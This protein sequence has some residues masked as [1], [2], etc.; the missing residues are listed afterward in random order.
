MSNA[1]VV[2]TSTCYTRLMTDEKPFPRVP[3][4]HDLDDV[5]TE[6]EDTAEELTALYLAIRDQINEVERT[7]T[8]NQLGLLCDTSYQVQ[9]CS[10]RLAA[11]KR[12]IQDTRTAL[13]NIRLRLNKA[14]LSS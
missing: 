9:H 1:I 10:G 5:L 12:D 6:I 11:A 8:G 14:G 2:L 4:P 13:P 7:A 3:S